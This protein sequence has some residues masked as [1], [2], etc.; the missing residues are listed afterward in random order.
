MHI[1]SILLEK[2]VSRLMTDKK[3]EVFTFS[4]TSQL[5]R[6][7]L[8]CIRKVKTSRFFQPEVVKHIFLI[9]WKRCASKFLA[10]EHGLTAPHHLYGP[11]L[12]QKR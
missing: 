7:K 6:A 8:T 2:Y 11:V 10:L 9:K 1:F 3:R 12:K 4:D 5:Y